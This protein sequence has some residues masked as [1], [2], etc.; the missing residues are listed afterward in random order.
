MVNT[1]AALIVGLLSFVIIGLSVVDMS[2]AAEARRGV[3]KNES[4]A[5]SGRSAV[6]AASISCHSKPPRPDVARQ[7]V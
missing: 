1:V 7:F 5:R 6:C 3:P 4:S 2:A